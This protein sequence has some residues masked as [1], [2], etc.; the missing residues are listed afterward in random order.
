MMTSA[1]KHLT[2][3]KDLVQMFSHP[4]GLFFNSSVCTRST[5]KALLSVYNHRRLLGC[6][7][8]G[9]CVEKLMLV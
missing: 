3:M 7:K 4:D 1:Q 2:L 6:E 8:D 9:G 5:A